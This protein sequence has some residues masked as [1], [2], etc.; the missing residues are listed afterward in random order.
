MKTIG[1]YGCAFAALGIGLYTTQLVMFIC[2]PGC[3]SD[4]DS[5]VSSDFRLQSDVTGRYD[6]TASTYDSSVDSFE[7]LSGI[8]RIR[9]RM[10]GQARGRVLE[11]GVGTGRN[12][13]YYNL[14]RGFQDHRP[15][16]PE[17]TTPPPP[18][19]DK[20]ESI[21]FV[22]P[23]RQMLELARDK[24][25]N[26][27]G[28]GEIE[29]WSRWRWNLGGGR[30]KWWCGSV[31][32]GYVA[33]PA[34]FVS[35]SPSLQS[36][37]SPEPVLYDTVIQT[38]SLCSTTDPISHIR[39]LALLAHPDR[40]RVLLLEHGRGHYNWL[41]SALDRAAPAHAREH[42]CWWNRDIGALLDEAGVVVKSVKRRHLG[43]L[44]E[45]EVAPASWAE[46]AARQKQI[47]IAKDVTPPT[48]AAPDQDRSSWA[49]WKRFWPR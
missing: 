18:P 39:N 29:W 24:W 26:L 4:P 11:A 46:R 15:G 10:I 1:L 23:S 43:T 16:M 28:A 30:V 45:I 38:L 3:P 47:E 41:N 49:W 14:H 20:V 7:W 9:K 33:P 19:H 2:R 6:I 27:Y 48:A 36:A 8:T 34:D 44:W 42:G 5:P 12:M 22:D 31:L 25:R 21:V 17:S 13:E 40:G 35:S 37:E 32:D